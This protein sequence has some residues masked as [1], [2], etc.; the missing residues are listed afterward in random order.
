MCGEKKEEREGA[1]I[2]NAIFMYAYIALMI[3]INF[4]FVNI[5]IATMV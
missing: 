4:P 2:P 5:N 3:I 1:N